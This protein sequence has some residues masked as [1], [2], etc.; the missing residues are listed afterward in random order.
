MNGIYLILCLAIIVFLALVALVIV[1]L[2]SGTREEAQPISAP[3][4]VVVN[5]TKKQTLQH[6]LQKTAVA[7]HLR[8]EEQKEKPR[9]QQNTGWQRPFAFIS[10][11]LVI[12]LWTIWGALFFL[13]VVWIMRQNPGADSSFAITENEKKSAR[14]IYVWLL[15]SPILILPVF[16]ILL[17]N[18]DFPEADT[19]TRA[20]I[21]IV[22]LFV[23]LLLVTGLA[24]K[25]AFEYR[26]TQ[27]AILLIALRAGVATLAISVGSYPIDGI[28]LFLLGNGS[29]WLLGSLW[30]LDQV[31]RGECWLMEQKGETRIMSNERAEDL[32]PQ[33]HLERSREFIKSYNAAEAKNHALAAFRGGDRQIRSQAVKLL[34][35]LHEVEEF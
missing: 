24:S 21:T 30:G 33:I 28:W 14:G 35:A 6:N 8:T 2:K 23:H 12:A 34:S 10:I 32:S 11:S 5:E 17:F 7:D 22:P 27:Q 13:A 15:L 1:I 29:L 3:A 16:L 19:N 20:L 31:S 9:K 25:S 26:H 18:V 4:R